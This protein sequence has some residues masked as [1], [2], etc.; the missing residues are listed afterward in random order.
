MLLALAQREPGPDPVPLLL[1]EPPNQP[2]G[3]PHTASEEVGGEKQ[4]DK[5]TSWDGAHAPAWD[6]QGHPEGQRDSV[7]HW[8]RSPLPRVTGLLW[9]GGF[10]HSPAGKISQDGEISKG[11]HCP[12]REGMPGCYLPL[13]GTFACSEMLENSIFMALL[14]PE[15]SRVGS[16]SGAPTCMEQDGSFLQPEH[17]AIRNNP[18]EK[19]ECKPVRRRWLPDSGVPA[20]EPPRHRGSESPLRS[21]DLPLRPLSL[22]RAWFHRAAGRHQKRPMHRGFC[23]DCGFTAFTVGRGTRQHHLGLCSLWHGYRLGRLCRSQ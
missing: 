5:H 23:T 16:G 3:F 17:I 7:S 18:P 10:L 19:P 1:L 11:G 14:D 6:V 21:Q 20:G 8:S 2:R 22:R 4:G 12:F 15:S 9:D 13:K